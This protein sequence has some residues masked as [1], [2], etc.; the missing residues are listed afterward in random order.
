MEALRQQ[1][2]SSLPTSG[3][4]AV[5]IVQAGQHE[6]EVVTHY[7]MENSYCTADMRHIAL[8]VRF[9]GKQV[10]IVQTVYTRLQ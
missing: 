7:C 1:S 6:Y 9:A 10:Y 2:P 4:S 3:S 5:Q 8:E